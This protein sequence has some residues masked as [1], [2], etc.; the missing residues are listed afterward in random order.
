VKAIHTRPAGRQVVTTVLVMC[1][2]VACGLGGCAVRKP[3]IKLRDIEVA[4]MDFQK[5]DLVLDF[6]VTNPNAYQIS[7]Y[8][9]EYGLSAAGEK[10][11]GGALPRPVAPLAAKEIAVVKVPVALEY[12][13]LL[14]LLEKSAEG[15]GIDYELSTQATFDFIGFKIGVPLKRR[16]RLPAL[17]AP[18]WRFR[19]VNWLGEEAGKLALTFEVENPNPFTLVLKNLSGALR[20]GDR[21]LLPVDSADLSPVPAGKTEART[22]TVGLE[23]SA[24]AAV[25][26][27][28]SE[29]R[30]LS[31][32]GTLDLAPPVSLHELLIQGLQKDE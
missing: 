30:S 32:E 7:L 6:A 26:K 3:S 5:L 28:I 1:A 11:A 25:V 9:L 17:R 24:T 27:A 31:F 23:A 22:V 29:P 18:A 21:P 13:S 8:G 12:D 10:F 19:E 2:V 16:G 20:L 15:E 4:G 14:P